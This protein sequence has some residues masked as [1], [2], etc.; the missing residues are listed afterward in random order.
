MAA[1]KRGIDQG[2]AAKIIT[3]TTWHRSIGAQRRSSGTSPASCQCG[4]GVPASAT[5]AAR[6]RADIFQNPR[7]ARV[8]R[9]PRPPET[10]PFLVRARDWR[11]AS[12][13]SPRR[14]ARFGHGKNVRT[15]VLVAGGSRRQVDSRARN[16]SA[17]QADRGNSRLANSR[18]PSNRRLIG[19][20]LQTRPA[21]YRTQAPGI[22]RLGDC[23]S[24]VACAGPGQARGRFSWR[25]RPSGAFVGCI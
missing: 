17:P 22:G 15:S 16:G 18:V 7:P 2:P 5:T 6:I 9:R 20:S 23:G 13:S 4:D 12:L 25:M 19:T 14:A 1:S 24:G 11:L 8:A 3:R 10:T 21:P